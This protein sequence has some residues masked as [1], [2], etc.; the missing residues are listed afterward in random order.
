MTDLSRYEREGG[1]CPHCGEQATYRTCSVC[2]LSAW[3]IDCGH[4]AQPRPIAAGK[5]GGRE[6]YKTFCEDCAEEGT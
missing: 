5:V 4:Y 6:G 2:G 3:I 1:A